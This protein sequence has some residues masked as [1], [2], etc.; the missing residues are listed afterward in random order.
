MEMTNI[1]TKLKMLQDI[2]VEKYAIELRIEEAP[3]VLYAQDELLARLKKEYIEKNSTYEESKAKI[4]TLR[5][6]LDETIMARERGEKGM[7][8]IT[9]HREYEALDKEIKDAEAKEA[10]VRNELKKEEKFFAE[11]DE[12]MQ[13]TKQ[14]ID[15]QQDEID[16]AKESISGTIESLKQ[17]LADLK[18]QE[19]EIIP[20]LDS[21][22]VFKFERI[23]KNKQNKGIVAVKGNVCDGCHMILP[24]QFAN[25]VRKGDNIVFCPYCSRILFYQHQEEGED[26]YYNMDDTGSLVDLDDD[27]DEED[28]DYESEE[29]DEIKE[30]DFGE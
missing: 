7:D 30:M 1:F 3:K 23:I 25:E 9:T 4:A 16:K 5:R 28:E 27:F 8:S 18:V 17:T 29:R 20:D 10:Q 15:S 13:R 2:L 21:E 24:A 22:V 12:E 14:S 26:E 11:L 6:E 19:D